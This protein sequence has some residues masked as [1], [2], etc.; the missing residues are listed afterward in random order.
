MSVSSMLK[1]VFNHLKKSYLIFCS[2]CIALAL[3]MLIP[4]IKNI[5]IDQVPLLT[6]S[7]NCIIRL[8]GGNPDEHEENVTEEEIRI[9]YPKEDITRLVEYHKWNKETSIYLNEKYDL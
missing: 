8:M 4:V 5:T 3:V 6:L 2:S 7:T 1:M 9:M